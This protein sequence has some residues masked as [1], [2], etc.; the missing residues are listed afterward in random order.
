MEQKKENPQTPVRI[1]QKMNVEVPYTPLVLPNQFIGKLQTA[2]PNVQNT[3][4]FYS[5]TSGTIVTHFLNGQD[6]QSIKILGNGHTTIKHFAS[7]PDNIHTNTGAN[8]LLASGLVYTF[9][10]FGTKWYEDE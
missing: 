7:A 2:T 8:K 5:H 1:R 6:G 10:F 3:L 9:T 4:F